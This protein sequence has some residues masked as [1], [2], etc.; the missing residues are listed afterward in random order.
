MAEAALSPRRSRATSPIWSRRI[1]RNRTNIPPDWIPTHARELDQLERISVD[2][3]TREPGL[4]VWPEVP[5]PF[6]LQDPA[7]R[8]RAQRIAREAGSDFLVGVVDWKKDAAGKWIA[9]N[10]AVLL[11]PLGPAHFYI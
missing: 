5:A 8:N 10:S 11:N 7:F 3:A 6:S 2:A 4:I 1:F 9:S